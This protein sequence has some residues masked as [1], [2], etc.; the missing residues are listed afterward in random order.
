MPPILHLRKE[1]L[2]H[3]FLTVEDLRVL[4]QTK[5][6]NLH[7]WEIGN[8][9]L[10]H[11]RARRVIRKRKYWHEEVCKWEV[12]YIREDQWRKQ[13]RRKAH[14]QPNQCPTRLEPL[15]QLTRTTPPMIGGGWVRRYS[16]ACSMVLVF[17]KASIA[18]SLVKPMSMS[19]KKNVGPQNHSKRENQMHFKKKETL[20]RSK[21]VFLSSRELRIF[22]S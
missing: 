15:S 14:Q 1:S 2:F 6:S 21:Q 7:A 3:G 18:C 4:L 13:E 11:S 17:N 20:S 10:L 9:C 16:V 8:L 19:Y 12:V 5:S 22:I